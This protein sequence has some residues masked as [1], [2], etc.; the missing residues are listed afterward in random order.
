MA[1]QTK[2]SG[3]SMSLMLRQCALVNVRTR[4]ARHLV[5][6]DEGHV[7]HCPRDNKVSGN[8]LMM[9]VSRV[10]TITSFWL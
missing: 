3:H 6:M 1:F 8:D 10:V 7:M 9:L 2:T 5:S 4:V